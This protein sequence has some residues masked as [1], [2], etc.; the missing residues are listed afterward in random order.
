[1]RVLANTLKLG[2]IEAVELN[3]RRSKH[4]QKKSTWQKHSCVVLLSHEVDRFSKTTWFL[5]LGLKIRFH[6]KFTPESK[7]PHDASIW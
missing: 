1:M 7:Y 2:H 6:N 4:S 5:I 3:T